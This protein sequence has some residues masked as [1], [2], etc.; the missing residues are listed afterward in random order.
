MFAKTTLVA[1]LAALGI[2]GAAIAGDM[3]RIEDPYARAAS[4]TAKAGAAFMTI[5]NHGAEDDRLIAASSEAAARVEL[6]THR[7]GADG[8]MRMMHV[9]EGFVIPAGGAHA[10]I[11]GGDHV[12]F[13]G[14]TAPFEQGAT[15]KVTLSFEKAGD[16]EVE[17]PVDLHRKPAEGT[18]TH[19]H[20]SHGT[21][22]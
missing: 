12:M 22:G 7:E 19:G 16:V 8:V 5:A 21:D 1:I 9:A 10:L 11:R 15:V 17:I 20:K 18:M 4:P 3:I 13:M 6:H 2:A 14:L